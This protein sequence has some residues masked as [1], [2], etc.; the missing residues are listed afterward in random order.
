MA[1]DPV[2][3]DRIRRHLA[4]RHDVV[5]KRM[6]GGLSFS[7][8]GRMCCGVTSSGLMVR[9]GRDGVRPALEEPHVRP[10][11]LGGRPL[12]AFVLVDPAG[13]ADDADLARWLDRAVAC[14]LRRE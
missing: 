8:G 2:T 4:A 10:M 9:V 13:Y 12:A 7:V 5:E 1:S 6:V 11:E 3:A 14:V